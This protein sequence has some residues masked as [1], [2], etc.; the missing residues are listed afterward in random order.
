MADIIKQLEIPG[1]PAI[2]APD[3]NA[4]SAGSVVGPL[5]LSVPGEP[6]I[7]LQDASVPGQLSCPPFSAVASLHGTPQLQIPLQPMA[8][9]ASLSCS[10]IFVGVVVNCPPFRAEGS[11]QA[12][13]QIEVPSQALT[14]KASL[15]C[16]GIHAGIIIDCPPFVATA[17]MSGPDLQHKL[18]CPPFKAEA[19]AQATPQIQIFVEPFRASGSFSISDVVLLVPPLSANESARIYEKIGLQWILTVEE[20]LNVCEAIAAEMGWE[21]NEYLQ[22]SESVS[23]LWSGTVTVTDMLRAFGS[24]CICQVFNETAAESLTI[25][26]TTSFVHRMITSVA[27][28]LGISGVVTPAMTFN[29]VIAEA[30]GVVAAVTV[31]RTLYCTAEEEAVAADALGWQWNEDVAESLKASDT[32]TLAFRAILALTENLQITETVLR[33]LRINETLSDALEI[34]ASLTVQQRLNLSVEETLTA[35]ITI[36]L[37]DELWECWVLNGN[38]FAP[39]V[40][41][42]FDFNSYA[43]FQNEAFGCKSKGIYVLTGATDAGRA[44]TPGIVLPETYFGTQRK[45]R[46]RKAY[47]GLSGGTTPA[48]R[49]ET[50]SG[51]ATYTITDSKAT[52]GRNLYGRT[53]T[54]KLQG[55]ESLDFIELA[56]IILTR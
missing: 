15:H 48:I 25:T 29:R 39:S 19:A 13:P 16:S 27:E 18:S 24:V 50:E 43:V 2:S 56:P 34:I 35:G 12:T 53:W 14:A 44:I 42:G 52:I 49:L 21:I 26:D 4:G 41:S 9:A 11:L 51:S 32:A 23:S 8:A 10:G 30:L 1:F 3:A 20:T 45:K 17:S 46:F 55:F 40:Y 54:L 6:S 31:I 36:L 22:A 38:Q 33:S 5:P 37:G 47:F 7:T 28:S